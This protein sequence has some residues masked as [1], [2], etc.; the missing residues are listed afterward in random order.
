MKSAMKFEMMYQSRMLSSKIAMKSM[1]NTE[2]SLE[3]FN[4]NTFLKNL[5]HCRFSAG[6]YDGNKT[7]IYTEI[8]DVGRFDTDFLLK[9]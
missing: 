4:K 8:E 5:K 1:K 2:K 6:Y 7:P 9:I 3:A